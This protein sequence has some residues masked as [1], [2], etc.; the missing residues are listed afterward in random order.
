MTRG[1]TSH[2]LPSLRP[3]P[4]VRRV[5]ALG[6]FR[7]SGEGKNGRESWP[8]PYGH[9]AIHLGCHEEASDVRDEVGG[10]TRVREEAVLAA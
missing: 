10:L 9:Q 6:D 8:G 1:G 3:S 7:R 5:F 4:S 2:C